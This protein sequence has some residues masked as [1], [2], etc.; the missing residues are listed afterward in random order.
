MVR[1]VCERAEILAGAIALGEASDLE[2]E[3]YRAHLASCSACLAAFGG[4]REI[5]RVMASIA[6]ARDAET[7][8]PVI[9]PPW[10]LAARSRNRAWRIGATAAGVAL[11]ASLGVHAFVAYGLN[12]V[13]PTPVNPIVIDYDGRHLTLERHMPV[14]KPVE[15]AKAPAPPIV[16]LHNVVHL[17]SPRR[18]A[19]RSAPRKPQITV[20]H[21]TIVVAQRPPTGS[22]AASETP[23]WRL[24]PAG[25]ASANAAAAAQAPLPP[26]H[27]A[28]SMAVAVP[29]S[30]HEVEPIGGDAAIDP[31]PPMIAAAEGANGTTAFEL[32][33]NEHGVPTKC[34]ITKASGYLV[35]DHAVCK[36]A[37]RAR[38]LPRTING[39]GVPSVYRDAFTFRSNADQ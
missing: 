1:N 25:V 14:A 39:R 8:E 2:R 35:L 32:S 4:E 24:N 37:M 33:I 29:P 31:V 10:Q 34:T 18:V 16:V 19:L 20:R 13:K 17:E 23:V 26:E 3:Q 15:A 11:A 27:R 30:I 28:E 21:R 38:F 6:R 36:A 22:A 5:E 7:W 12:A 9:A